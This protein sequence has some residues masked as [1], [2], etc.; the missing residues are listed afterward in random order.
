MDKTD[1]TYEEFIAR[2]IKDTVYRHTFHGI[3]VQGTWDQTTKIGVFMVNYSVRDEQYVR[4]II[5]GRVPTNLPGNGW[6][7]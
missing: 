5:D 3:E 4:A 1:M 2:C 7:V 6:G